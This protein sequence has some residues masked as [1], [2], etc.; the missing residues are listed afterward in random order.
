MDALL[1]DEAVLGR[2]RAVT[3][4]KALHLSADQGVDVEML[5]PVRGIVRRQIV[6]GFGKHGVARIFEK[7]RS[8]R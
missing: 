7:P 3:P 4:D 8:I 2:A 5:K 6:A 1:R